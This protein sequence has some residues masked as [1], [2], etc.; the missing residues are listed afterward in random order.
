MVNKHIFCFPLNDF[1]YFYIF[2]SIYF[3]NLEVKNV[4][5]NILAGGVLSAKTWALSF[6]A[7]QN[8]PESKFSGS[9][10]PL[11]VKK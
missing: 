6:S 1:D 2:S 9:K 7:A 4:V 8:A 5:P 3:S 11:W 10:S